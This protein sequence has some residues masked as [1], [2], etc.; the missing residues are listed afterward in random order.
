MSDLHCESTAFGQALLKSERLRVQI[1]IGTVCLALLLRTLRAVVAG[2]R[3]NFS[4]L[5]A[6]GGLLCLFLIYEFVMLRR[7][8]RAIQDGRQLANWAWFSN[9]ILET[10]LPALAVAFISSASIDPVYRPLAN[11]AGLA[12]F[13][14]IILSTLHLNPALCR[15]SGLT[16]AVSYLA[17]ATHLGWRPSMSEGTSLLSPERAVFGYAVA[18]V[19]AGFVAGVVAGEVRKQVEAALR[20]AETR[21]QVD[22]LEQDLSVARSIQQSLLPRTMPEVDGFEIAGWNRP[23]DQTGGD[24]YDWQ[25]LPDGKV[26][27]ALADVTG[28]GIG[29]ALLAA[30]CRAY[31][32]ANFSSS[33]GLLSAMERINAAVSIDV[34]EGR[35]VTFVAAVCD[36]ASSCVQL[37]SAGHGPLLL[38]VSKEDRFEQMGAQGLP[39]GIVSS[40]ISEPPR[41]LELNS[42]DI[43]VL[44]TDGF[45]EWANAQEE[46]FGLQRM[47]DVIRTSKN[48]TPRELISDLYQA[49]IA[50]SGGTKQQDDL[51]AV[52]IKRTSKKQTERAPISAESGPVVAVD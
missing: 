36:P 42:G 4:S 46:L 28:H 33:I 13:V 22:R 14:F 8:N 40:L 35:F 10:S 32:R 34:G 37:L 16:A 2:G 31:A 52:I 21:R 11:P 15:L 30:V 12:F 38:F 5:L 6:L 29:P 1:I 49:V 51:T 27:I 23:A 47:Q 17:A 26:V 7:V 41:V 20:E 24:Y 50:F 19:I 43:L 48:K 45:F 18:Y 44:V 25:V 9:I 3:E 39:L